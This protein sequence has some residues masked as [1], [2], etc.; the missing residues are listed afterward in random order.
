MGIGTVVAGSNW[1]GVISSGVLFSGSWIDIIY[2]ARVVCLG[3]NT[4]NVLCDI[5]SRDIVSGASQ[6]GV[7]GAARVLFVGIDGVVYSSGD[8][9]DGEGVRGLLS[10]DVRE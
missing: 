10:S 8:I 1:F 9:S 3:A 2:D 5:S 7:I 6:I 4:V